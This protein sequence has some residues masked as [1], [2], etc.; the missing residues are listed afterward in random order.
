MPESIRG[1][2]RNYFPVIDLRLLTGERAE[3]AAL[4]RVLEGAPRYAERIT[5]AP[6]GPDDAQSSYTVLPE[7]KGYE[8]KFV[9]GIYAGGEMIG[10]A[11]VIR[12]WPRPDTAHI[13]LLLI[14]ERHQR[15]GHGRAAYQA[16]ERA[17]APWG[18]KRVRIGVVGTN[19]DVLPF[20]RTLGFV[21][22]GEVKPYRYGPV[23]SQVTILEKPL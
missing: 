23:D 20:W 14:G 19:E 3:T 9:Y 7:G 12:G 21:P 10:C 13:G 22:T 1:Q 11:D 17:I 6:P 16:I 5:G 4:Q 2:G 18:V 15:R 8:D